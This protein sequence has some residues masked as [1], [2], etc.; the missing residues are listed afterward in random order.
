MGM[1]LLN[2]GMGA[3]KSPG[4]EGPAQSWKERREGDEI[5]PLEQQPRFF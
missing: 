5:W 1:T 3:T 2:L 4:G